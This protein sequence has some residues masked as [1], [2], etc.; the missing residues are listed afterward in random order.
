MASVKLVNRIPNYSAAA[1][2]GL[3]EHLEATAQ[4]ALAKAQE[5]APVDEGVLRAS[6]FYAMDSDAVATVG[7]T[8]E[9]AIYQ[10]LGTEHMPA[11]PYL[12]P[13]LE[14]VA[15]AFSDGVADVLREATP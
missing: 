1:R 5:K 2:A 12:V 14:E 4:Q 6:G 8:A 11:Q 7:F 3:R 13:A 15:Q 10:E 9:H